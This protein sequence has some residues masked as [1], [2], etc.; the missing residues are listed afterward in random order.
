MITSP[1]PTGGCRAAAPSFSGDN[2][3][4]L[5]ALG[6]ETTDQSCAAI[7]FELLVTWRAGDAGASLDRACAGR[8]A[9]R[10]RLPCPRLRSESDAAVVADIDAATVATASVAASLVL[11]AYRGPSEFV[12]ELAQYLAARPKRRVLVL[13]AIWLTREE[14]P[15]GRGVGSSQAMQQ[16]PGFQAARDDCR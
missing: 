11:A 3:E 7:S 12:I 9:V 6:I 4:R 13:L 14:R 16:L 2:L 15:S 5:D 8:P 10:R 1:S